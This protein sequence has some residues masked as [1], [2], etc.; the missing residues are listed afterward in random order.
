MILR[1]LI[2]HLEETSENG[3]NDN[4]DIEV[5]K[6]YYVGE[7]KGEGESSYHCRVKKIGNVVKLII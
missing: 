2:N 7:D 5:F 4:L 3:K 6:P 1:E